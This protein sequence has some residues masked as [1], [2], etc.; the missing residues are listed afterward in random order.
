MLRS[1]ACIALWLA[2]AAYA[3]AQ[4]TP[5][6]E[7][8]QPR[9]QAGWNTT[10]LFWPGETDLLTNVTYACTYTGYVVRAENRL[11]AFGSCNAEPRSC[12]GYHAL[13]PTVGND[14]INSVLPKSTCMKYSE[15][16]GATWSQIRMV[17]TVA[18]EGFA[19]GGLVY[20]N[21]TKTII[22]HFTTNGT[23][24]QTTSTDKGSTWS[25]LVNITT[26]LEDGFPSWASAP[27]VGPGNGVQLSPSNK[28]APGRLLFAG[29][30]GRY[31]YDAVW[32]SDDHA[33]TWKMALNETTGQPAKFMGLDEPAIA[34]TPSGGVILRAR[35][36][37]FHG[38]DK[39]NCRGTA[40]SNNGGTSFQGRVGFDAGLPEPVCQG[41]MINAGPGVIYSAMPGFGTSTEKK[42]GHDGRG[43]G[44]VRWSTD[45]GKTWLG[46]VHLWDNHAYSYSG[47]THVPTPGYIGLA[48]ETVLP[49]SGPHKR[50]ISANNILFTLIPTTA[51][52]WH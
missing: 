20:D 51:T 7:P 52:P 28:F 27:T 10:N 44:I 19:A 50:D 9:I 31:T 35:N 15:D 6:P 11:V 14:Y 40:D 41:T 29:H 30:H 37:E 48:W 46:N 23:V 2:L 47:L 1:P 21:V 26:F 43:N 22:S 36:F 34:E 3:G 32:Y 25:K 39:C 16:S 24:M 17:H 33:K 12:N 4:V 38:P 45:G 42:D 8:A 18:N 5:Q 49:D 13:P